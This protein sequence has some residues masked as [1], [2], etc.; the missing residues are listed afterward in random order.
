MHLIGHTQLRMLP[1]QQG[2]GLDDFAGFNVD[3]G[4]EIHSELFLC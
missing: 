4:L 1:A 2:L 3:N